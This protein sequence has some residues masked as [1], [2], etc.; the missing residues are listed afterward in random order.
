MSS[1]WN[2][3]ADESTSGGCLRGGQ[4]A[5]IGAEPQMET[6]ATRTATAAKFFIGTL[7]S[8]RRFY[9]QRS[10]HEKDPDRHN[11]W[12]SGSATQAP[13][14]SEV[15]LQSE[16]NDAG[17]APDG[18]Y[19]PE[20]GISLEVCAVSLFRERCRGAWIGELQVV[21]GIDE[22]GAKPNSIAFTP[23]PV[24]AQ[25]HIPVVDARAVDN[26]TPG[27]AKVGAGWAKCRGI[28][29][30]RDCLRTVGIAYKVGARVSSH[31]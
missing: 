6:P 26:P 30:L 4:V 17:V 7:C 21:K 1:K 31:P 13:Y 3:D 19:S 8:Q 23:P 12:R 2:R 27:R 15:E 16:L 18:S 29:P 11:H 28:E 25:G 14:G 9:D 20:V 5:P 22:V 10:F 24:L